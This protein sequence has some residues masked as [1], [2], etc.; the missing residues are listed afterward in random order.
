MKL[1]YAKTLIMIFIL[2][3]PLK[4]LHANGGVRNKNNSSTKVSGVPSTTHF[5][6]NNISTRISNDGTCDNNPNPNLEGL[7]YPKGTN[8]TAVFESGFVW[9]GKVNGQ[10]R[11]GG[12]TYTSGLQPGKIIKKGEAQNLQDP[13][14]RLFRVRSDFATADLSSEINDGEGTES[15][16]RQQYQ[17]D[18]DEWP[19]ADGAPF[20]DNDGDGIYNPSVDVPG[21]PGSNVTIFYIANDLDSVRT[22][23]LYGSPPVGLE[24]HVTVWGYKQIAPFDNMIFKRYQVINKSDTN[25]TDA[26]FGIWSDVDDGNASDDVDGCDTILN[27]GYTY[28]FKPDDNVYN[29]LPPPAVGFALLQG[30]I[31]N[32]NFNDIAKFNGRILYGKKNLPMTSFG[33]IFKNDPYPYSNPTLGGEYKGTIEMYNLLHG[34]LLDGQYVPVPIELGG[35]TT[36]FP[37]SGDP[38]AGTGFLDP[39]GFDHRLM[40]LQFLHLRLKQPD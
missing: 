13:S 30:P 35:R 15:Q 2:T 28:N 24:L 1:N 14:A 31:V 32:G 11:V 5:N 23:G 20:K 39:R 26:Y 6:I 7:I 37:Y 9:G 25:Y 27:L 38:F 34:Q 40:V 8:K 19:A 22:K 17:T 3:L 12:S 29:P 10:I 16:I 4:Q 33:Y 36:K 18:W 21:V